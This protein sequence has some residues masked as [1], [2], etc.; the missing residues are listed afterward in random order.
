MYINEF[1]SID[2]A[3]FIRKEISG[4]F[5]DHCISFI[6]N[7]KN[8]S[9]FILKKDY[10]KK[11]SKKILMSNALINKGPDIAIKRKFFNTY[12]FINLND[13]IL[14]YDAKKK[15]FELYLNKINNYKINKIKF[16]PQISYTNGLVVQKLAKGVNCIPEQI[17]NFNKHYFNSIAEVINTL[18]KINNYEMNV[19]DYVSKNNFNCN[20]NDLLNVEIIRKILFLLKNYNQKKIIISLTHGDFKFDHLFILN[21]NLEYLVDWEDAGERSI[22]YDLFNIFIPWFSRR[23]YNYQEIKNHIHKFTKIYIPTLFDEVF[24]CYD[25]YFLLYS[26]E[27]YNRFKDKNFNKEDAF[28]RYNVLVNKLIEEVPT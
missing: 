28:K 1:I 18:S 2:G 27:R 21:N 5:L 22:F 20:K 14:F 6:S 17:S 11:I 12:K 10:K 4:K 7:K 15:D 8:I 23:T 9:N 26:L 19:K 3:F 25:L 24:K 16:F 13:L